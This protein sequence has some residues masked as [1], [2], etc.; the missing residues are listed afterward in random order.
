[1]R[2]TQLALVFLV[3]ACSAS[4][5]LLVPHDDAATT[6]GTPGTGTGGATP[7]G[8]S[9]GGATPTGGTVGGA[10]TGGATPTG[11]SSGGTDAA[12][13]AP[14]AAPDAAVPSG[15]APSALS[16]AELPACGAGTQC[17]CCPLGLRVNHCTCSIPCTADDQ[18]PASAPHCNVR[19]VMNVPLGQGFCTSPAFLCAW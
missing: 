6:G 5:Q 4:D 11:G 8:G 2:P 12:A 13:D 19:Q 3:L 7:T 16:C 18:C 10:G 17:L 14:A 15:D 1:M 9:S